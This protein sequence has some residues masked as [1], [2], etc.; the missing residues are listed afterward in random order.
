VT[1]YAHTCYIPKPIGTCFYCGKGLEPNQTGPGKSTW[2]HVVPASRGGVTLPANLV[3]ACEGCNVAN[4]SLSL[5]QFRLLRLLRFQNQCHYKL[6]GFHFWG[7]R[8][9]A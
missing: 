9:A 5:E 8:R 6:T 1:F 7:E 3:L 4:G 2:D